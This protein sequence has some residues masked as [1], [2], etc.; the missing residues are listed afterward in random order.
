MR[1]AS[2]KV[3]YDSFDVNV[4]RSIQAVRRPVSCKRGCA[5]CCR[6][7]QVT[8]HLSEAFEIYH[9]L[10]KQNRLAALARAVPILIDES[11]QLSHDIDCATWKTLNKPCVFLAGEECSVYPVRPSQCRAW[12]VFS[13]PALCAGLGHV[14]TLDRTWI[15]YL[16]PILQAA[17]GH[18]EVPNTVGPLQFAMI[19]AILAHGM[20]ARA[21]SQII[22]GT[23]FDGLVSAALWLHLERSL[24][25]DWEACRDLG[26]A[27]IKRLGKRM[28]S[29]E[30][31]LSWKQVRTTLNTFQRIH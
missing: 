23:I 3:V 20:G 27:E 21:Y 16:I 24:R 18:A 4:Q 26:V 22:A 13:D 6:G 2:L 15:K 31:F 30:E 5:A 9:H 28:V 1:H 7:M 8:L 19:L 25:D 10:E 12:V 29:V 17:T 11:I 14:E